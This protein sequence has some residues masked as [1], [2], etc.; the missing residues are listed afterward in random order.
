MADEQPVNPPAEMERWTFGYLIDVIL[1][2]DTWMHR[3][4][5]A[6]A[7]GQPM[8]LTVDHDG[9]LIADVAVEWATRH[10]RPCTLTLTGLAGGSWSWGAGGPAYELDA[11]QFARILS[12]RGEG[13]GLLA[14]RVPF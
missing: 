4:D 7:T 5:I 10:G 11:V 8:T 13:D 9:L 2:R 6:D 14:T 1:T 12:G 3:S